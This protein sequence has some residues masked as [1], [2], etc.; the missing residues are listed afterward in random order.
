MIALLSISISYAPSSL[1]K[2]TLS[3]A[4]HHHPCLPCQRE[5]DWRHDTSFDIIAF[6][7]RYANH[8]YVAN[9]F[10]VKTE[11]LLYT[12]QPLHSNDD[13]LFRINKETAGHIINPAA[14][15]L[16]CY[17]SDNHGKALIDGYHWKLTFMQNE[18]IIDIIEGTNGED[19]RRYNQIKS[20]IEFWSAP[21]QV[22]SRKN[23]RIFRISSKTTLLRSR[24]V[25]LRRR[26][27]VVFH[28]CHTFQF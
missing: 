9:F 2:T 25:F 16:F 13:I 24:V 26:C 27:R 3:L 28:R 19:N 17:D 12:H 10:A 5:V 8:F 22:D 20:V 4:L 15:E 23:K 14:S 18:R 6:C 1:S 11:G 21:C 7:L